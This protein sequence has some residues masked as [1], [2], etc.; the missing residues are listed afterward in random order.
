MRA[1]SFMKY[2]RAKGSI[3]AKVGGISDGGRMDDPQVDGH[4]EF[5]AQIGDAREDNVGIGATK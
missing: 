5:V 4:L 2:G 3:L 1:L